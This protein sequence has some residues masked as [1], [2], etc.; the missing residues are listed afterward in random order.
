M[1]QFEMKPHVGVG[2]IQFGQSRQSVRA[3]MAELG[4]T[5]TESGDDSRDG[6]FD[7]CFQVHYDE[8]GNVE[9]IETASSDAFQ[10]TFHGEVLHEMEAGAA[11]EFVSQFADFDAEEPEIPYSYQFPSIELSLWR[12]TLP[13]DEDDEDYDEE[14]EEGRY[15][16]AV[17]LGTKGYFSS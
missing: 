14:D 7:Y 4:E 11:V 12:G 9:F 8:S 13:L 16:E 15:F 17:G 2:P 6:Y 1:L 5:I 3:T 10:V